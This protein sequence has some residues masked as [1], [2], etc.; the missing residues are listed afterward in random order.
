MNTTSSRHFVALLGYEYDL[1]CCFLLLPRHQCRTKIHLMSCALRFTLTVPGLV[2]DAAPQSRK[3]PIVQAKQR[4]PMLAVSTII[5]EKSSIKGHI[6]AEEM[7][8]K[9]YLLNNAASI[10][11]KR[12]VCALKSS[13][14]T[15]DRPARAPAPCTFPLYSVCKPR[16]PRR[17]PM[18][19]P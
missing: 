15:S 13:R 5:I 6:F 8:F 10:A 16:Y 14:S 3:A 9:R 17:Q 1:N 11:A 18:R 12:R 19:L 7:I 2:N 4:H